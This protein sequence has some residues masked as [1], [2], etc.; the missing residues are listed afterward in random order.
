LYQANRF[1]DAERV[2]E[3]VV[4]QQAND[5]FTRRALYQL[6]RAIYR[7]GRFDEAEATFVEFERRFAWDTLA[8]DAAYHRAKARLRA[9][10]L[11]GMLIIIGNVINHTRAT[12]VSIGSAQIF[13]GYDLAGRSLNQRRTAQKDR[14]LTP[15][16]D[17]L[18]AHGWDIGPA[19]GARAHNAG[20]LSDPLRAHAGLIE[21]D[22][23]KMVT[24]WEDLGLMRQV[25]PARIDQIDTGQPILL[26]DLLSPQVLFDRNRE[27]GSAFDGR[28]IG[29]DHDFAATDPPNAG[30][31]P[32]RWGLIIIHTVGRQS[33]DFEEGRPHIEQ[34][35]NTLPG[36]ELASRHVTLTR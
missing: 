11:E 25:R 29:H 22:A 23:A 32:S 9:D 34:S 19:C 10:D 8:D 5:P 33:P 17:G 31:D 13:G 35:L 15:D 26:S 14:A 6:G 27:I 24:V 20:N 21:K 28:V 7:Q 30:N 36:Q 16:D 18:I 2:L 4:A 1:A 3:P 12:T